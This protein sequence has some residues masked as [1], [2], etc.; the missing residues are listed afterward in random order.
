MDTRAL[1]VLYA[2]PDNPPAK[3]YVGQ[4]MDVFLAVDQPDSCLVQANAP[5]VDPAV[6]KIEGN[7]QGRVHESAAPR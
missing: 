7:P 1:Q 2:L 5:A 6:T 3:V 4:Q